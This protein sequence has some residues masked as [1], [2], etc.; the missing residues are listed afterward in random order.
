MQEI[1]TKIENENKLVF[2]MGDVRIYLLNYENY[3]HTS[4]FLNTFFTN[5]LQPLVLQPTRVTDSTSTLIDNIF[6]NDVTSKV[7]SG[8]ILIQISDHFPQFSILKNSAL[9]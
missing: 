2:I 9:D 1:M 4:D 3:T 5:H 8:N 6:S 7:T